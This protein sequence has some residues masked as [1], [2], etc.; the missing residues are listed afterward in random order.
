MAE[1]QSPISRANLGSLITVLGF[2]FLTNPL[3]SQVTL[4]PPFVGTNSETWE[5]FG[6]AGIPN[7]TSILGGIATISG[8]DMRTATSFVMCSVI[9]VTS[10]G[11]ILM[12]SDRP[13]GPLVISFSRPVSA[14]G[15]YWGS[16]LHCPFGDAASILTFQDAAGNIIGTDRFTYMGDGTL[17]WRGYQFCTPVKTI[18]RTPSD[19][20][21]GVAMDGLQA[22]VVPP[23]VAPPPRAVLP[24]MNGDSETDFVL[25]NASTR[26]T[27]VWY[28]N[29]NVVLSGAY[30]PTIPAGWTLVGAADFNGDGHPDFVLFNQSMGQTAVWYMNNNVELSG[31]YGPTIPAGWQLLAT[32]DFNNDRKPDYVLYN[33]AT[34]QT[35]VWYLNN[36]AQ[37]GGDFGPTLPANWSLIGAADFNH[38]GKPDYLLFNPKTQQSAIWYLNNT[39]QIGGDFGP[40]LPANWS[41]IGAA[42]FNHDG[43]P[44]Y[45]LFNPDTQQSAI[46]YMNDNVE[47]TGAYGPT[48]PSGW[49]WP[50]P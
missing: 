12:D 18:T 24:D 11:T 8:D 34:K 29:N 38:D 19:G 32:A 47:L 9:G 48:L 45:L 39:A 5:R 20:K 16:G 23:P 40:T 30:G 10:D 1:L 31:A 35:A 6:V 49:S 22:N 44:D 28:M 7:G 3:Y 15:A 14:F 2:L 46:W 27:A 36:T 17:M 13:T 43:K 21:E 4:L 42:D 25:Y 37:I 26:Q 41:L 50:T 33:P